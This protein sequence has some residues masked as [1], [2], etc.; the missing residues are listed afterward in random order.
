MSALPIHQLPVQEQQDAEVIYLVVPPTV[1]A[2][3][4]APRPFSLAERASLWMMDFQARSRSASDK[5]LA[6]S[7]AVFA[8]LVIGLW[9]YNVK[10]AFGIDI[11]PHQHL[12]NF[13][14]LPGWQR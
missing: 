10:S 2:P 9:A 3:M 14:P 7:F 5:A 12:E 1:E 13:A 6:I 11:F 8:T 4:A